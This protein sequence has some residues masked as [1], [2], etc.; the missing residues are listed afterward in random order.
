MRRDRLPQPGRLVVKAMA[1]LG[2]DYPRERAERQA[3]SDEVRRGADSSAPDPR[4]GGK[5]RAAADV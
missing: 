1:M 5:P 2:V 3:P 4:S